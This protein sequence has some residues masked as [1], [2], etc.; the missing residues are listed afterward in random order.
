MLSDYSLETQIQAALRTCSSMEV[1][2]QVFNH[3]GKKKTVVNQYIYK[4]FSGDARQQSGKYLRF[5]MLS[6]SISS[7]EVDHFIDKRVF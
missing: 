4:Y 1:I 2:T 3:R 6:K 7:F 5:Y